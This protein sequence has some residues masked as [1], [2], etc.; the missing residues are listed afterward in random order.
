MLRRHQIISALALLTASAAILALLSL[1]RPAHSEEA[2]IAG[3]VGGQTGANSYVTP[4]A[5]LH[6]TIR[7]QGGKA[8][9]VTAFGMSGSGNL[10]PLILEVADAR[11]RVIAYQDNSILPLRVFVPKKTG[12]YTVR[13]TNPMPFVLY[14][15]SWS[16]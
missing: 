9:A 10:W 12:V 11:G 14:I 2:T 16:N 5:T 13:V 1:V 4:G 8:A 3:A 7:F 15:A 6:Y